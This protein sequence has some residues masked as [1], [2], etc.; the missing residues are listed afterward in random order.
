MI[1][2]AFIIRLTSFAGCVCPDVCDILVEF[3]LSIAIR[4]YANTTTSAALSRLEGIHSIH[5]SFGLDLWRGKWSG[6]MEQGIRG[7]IRSG[8]PRRKS[9]RKPTGKSRRAHV[10]A[11]GADRAGGVRDARCLWKEPKRALVAAGRIGAASA[12][13]DIMRL[14]GPVFPSHRPRAEANPSPNQV[15]HK[16]GAAN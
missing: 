7:E 2:L 3:N 4:L 14:H 5:L 6:G 13:L 10:L 11:T 15:V 1:W 8:T 12:V 9:R 16:S